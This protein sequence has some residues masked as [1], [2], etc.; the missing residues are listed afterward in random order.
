[1]RHDKFCSSF[2]QCCDGHKDQLKIGL[3]E[4]ARQ[5]KRVF[6]GLIAVLSQIEIGILQI[7]GANL[8]RLEIP[9]K[10]L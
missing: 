4:G 9:K 2:T 1:M 3:L 6:Y 10:R 7:E 8:E 5:R